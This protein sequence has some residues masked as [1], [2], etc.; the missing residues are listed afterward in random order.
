[1]TDG[2][3]RRSRLSFKQRRTAAHQTQS[4]SLKPI[5]GF[6]DGALFPDVVVEGVVGAGG[7]N[8]QTRRFCASQEKFTGVK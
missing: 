4:V 3:S 7:A 8:F 5:H 1:M 2:R 6:G